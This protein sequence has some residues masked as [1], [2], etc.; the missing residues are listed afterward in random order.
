MKFG[1]WTAKAVEEWIIE[2]A[3]TLRKLP[4]ARG[5][6]VFGNA[7]PEALRSFEESY[8]AHAARY[9]ENASAGALARME[10][11]FGWINALPQEADRKLIYA[12]SW[13]KV[14]R[15]RTISAFAEENAF[16]ERTLRR[17]VTAICQAIA[18]NLNQKG[19][20]RLLAPDC[21]VSEVQADIASTTVTSGNCVTAWR[22]PD[23]KP[24]VDPALARRR[25]LEPRH[26]RAR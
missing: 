13:V 11:V 3:D 5:P 16:N 1:D 15:G 25:V 21:A 9:R 19:Q 8:G 10:Q 20:V 23:A 17:A 7:M 18:D 26:A 24:Q 6:K 14:R 12:W 2:M 4:A 22:S